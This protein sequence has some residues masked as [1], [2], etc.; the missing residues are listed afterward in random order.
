MK[1]LFKTKV[2][3]VLENGDEIE[4]KAWVEADNHDSAFVL[5][6]SKFKVALAELALIPEIEIDKSKIETGA[7]RQ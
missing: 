7:D 2:T 6:Q 3:H 4:M 5:A 1:Q